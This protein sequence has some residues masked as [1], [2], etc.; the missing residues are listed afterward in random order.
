MSAVASTPALTNGRSRSGFGSVAA[1]MFPPLSPI[2][3]RSDQSY[4]VAVPFRLVRMALIRADSWPEP[5]VD[6][7]SGFVSWRSSILPRVTASAKARNFVL[8]N[9]TLSFSAPTAPG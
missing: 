1:K 2:W 9:S 7:P 6:P 5:T 4:V 8:S 3:L